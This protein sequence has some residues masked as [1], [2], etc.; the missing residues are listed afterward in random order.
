MYRIALA[1]MAVVFTGALGA[2]NFSISSTPV[3]GLPDVDGKIWDVLEHNG[4][5]YI[6]GEF[7]TVGATARNRLAEIDLSTNQVTS[8]NPDPDLFCSSL[9]VHSNV[10]YVGG[11]F[12][13]MGTTARESLASFDLSSHTLTNWNP[14]C[15]LPFGANNIYFDADVHCLYL[16]GATLYAGR[17]CTALDGT[18]RG[19]ECSLHP[20]HP[21]NAHGL[22]PLDPN[23]IS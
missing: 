8:W 6:A 15:A 17:G 9:A 18:P 20:H 13:Q 5:L 4:K 3:A 2:Q 23:L 14:T 16:Q 1:L 12:T 19:P 22:P 21:S 11:G 10:L 7:T